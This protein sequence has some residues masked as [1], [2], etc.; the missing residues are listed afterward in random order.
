MIKV[1]ELWVKLG[2]DEVLKGVSAVFGGKHIILGPNGSGKTTL[3]KAVA[4][5]APYRGASRSTAAHWRS[6]KVQ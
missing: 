1:E 6:L 4:G 2:G 5:L 3:F